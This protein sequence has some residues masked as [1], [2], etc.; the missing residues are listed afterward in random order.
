MN[1]IQEMEIASIDTASWM[2]YV[3]KPGRQNN[4]EYFIP[5]KYLNPVPVGKDGS[6]LFAPPEVGDTCTVLITEQQQAYIL[7]YNVGVNRITGGTGG[8]A[9]KEG[10][11]TGDLL[12]INKI[13]MIIKSSIMGAFHFIVDSWARLMIGR[14]N[15]EIRGFFRNI[16]WRARGGRIEW[17]TSTEQDVSQY[18]A[19]YSDK[20][21]EEGNSDARGEPQVPLPV[22]A[23]EETPVYANKVIEKVGAWSEGLKITDIRGGAV[24]AGVI[25]PRR[26]IY[27]HMVPDGAELDIMYSGLAGGMSVKVLEGDDAIN[28]VADDYFTLSIGTGGVTMYSTGDMN[29]VVEGNMVLGGEGEEQQ[30]VTKKFVEE[31][32]ANHTHMGNSGAPT[33]VPLNAGSITDPVSRDSNNHFTK[34]MV[35]E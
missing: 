14:T 31:I 25:P 7:G 21:E 22:Y 24:D 19:V 3:C 11:Q 29:L 17:E 1:N 18:L 10:L 16:Y 33:G 8:M 9:F 20:F 13:G 23:D 15:Q 27:K 35:A 4:P 6:G 28:I 26:H 34:D 30:L 12:H 32:F 2:F 5:A